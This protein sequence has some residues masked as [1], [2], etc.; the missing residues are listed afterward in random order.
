MTINTF[1]LLLISTSI[2]CV[3]KNYVI[4]QITLV[5]DFLVGHVISYVHEKK[6]T[7]T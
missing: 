2:I 7:L 1:Y 3:P 6:L 5:I 4:I